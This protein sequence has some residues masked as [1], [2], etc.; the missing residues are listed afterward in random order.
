[1]YTYIY[2]CVY[3]HAHI[4]TYIN[5]STY[6]SVSYQEKKEEAKRTHTD[7]NTWKRD[8]QKHHD[9]TSGEPV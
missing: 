7:R 3:T 5:E 6:T 2:T 4:H 9:Y 1:M 8:R